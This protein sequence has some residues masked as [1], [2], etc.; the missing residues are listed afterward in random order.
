ML[1]SERVRRWLKFALALGVSAVFIGIFVS[2]V[3]I[4][5]V[6]DALGHANYIYVIPAL[7]LFALS[8]ACRAV[9]WRYFLLPAHEL[10]WRQ[11]LPSVLVAYAGN[12]LLPFR[13]GELIRAQSL[14][15][16][17]AVPRMRTLGAL[18]MERLF[19][20]AV[21]ATFVLWGLLLVDVGTAY[22]GLGVLLALGAAVGFV[23]CTVIVRKPGIVTWAA[24]IPFLPDGLRET[25]LGWGGSFLGGF[26]VLTSWSRFALASV[27]SAAAWVLELSMYYMIAEAFDLKTSFI[28]V[29]F[30][31]SAANV[32]LSLPSAQGGIGP[33]QVF[34]T[35]ALQK[36]DVPQSDAAAYALAL[37]FFLIVPVSLVGLAVLWRS[38]LP[39]RRA[40]IAA[41]TLDEP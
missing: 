26:T 13:A 37:H 3:D 23:V 19:D 11:L 33:F 38:T 2:S 15:D 25:L 29:A 39:T 35:E 1:K 32:S 14:A 21:L 10:S 40:A 34:A 16:A 9:R 20:G 30:A 17:F 28:S 12:N 36:F 18:L 4:D 41:A 8:V 5:A 24:S 31:G 22:L 6:L 7:A 27:W